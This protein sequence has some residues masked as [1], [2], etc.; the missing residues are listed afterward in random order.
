MSIVQLKPG[1]L[2]SLKTSVRG[3][4]TYRRVDLDADKEENREVTE[5]KT[6]RVIDDVEVN[7]RATKVRSKARSLI[8][9]ACTSSAF[10]LLCRPDKEKAL[11]EAELEANAL[12]KQ[13]NESTS[14][15]R[16]SIYVMRGRIAESDEVAARA[17][18]SEVRDMIDAMEAG[19]KKADPDAIRAAAVKARKLGQMLDPGS[20]DKIKAAIEEARSA[21]SA[22]GRR[23]DKAGEDA[24]KVI[25]ELS[26]AKLDEAR[27]AFL[28]LDEA[29][30]APEGAS[31]CAPARELDLDDGVEVAAQASAAPMLEV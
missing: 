27:F 19:I 29:A 3:G 25:Q 16:V 26:R 20:Q 9:S 23:I 31:A 14:N 30:A 4:V 7:K 28:D 10:G 18:S 15:V 22:I 17:I 21:A 24:A 8:T 2:V 12:A 11:D 5:W 6:T 1:L 13:F